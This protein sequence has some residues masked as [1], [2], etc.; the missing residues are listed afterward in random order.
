[1]AVVAPYRFG[2]L[3]PPFWGQNLI[4]Y[5]D[6]TD[7]QINKIRDLTNKYYEK[8]KELWNKLYDAVFS[9]RQLQ[10]QRQLDKTQIDKE[11]EEISNIRKEINNTL[12]EYWKEFKGILTKEQLSKLT[13][14]SFTPPLRAKRLPWGYCPFF[15]W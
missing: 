9:L 15:R 12:S 11:K 2:I 4:K 7:E 14:R 1:P 10:F 8:L 3:E 13:D 6:L 5:L